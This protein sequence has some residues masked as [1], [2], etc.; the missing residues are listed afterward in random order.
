[1]QSKESVG[2]QQ[3][4][5][6]E[7]GDVFD[8]LTALKNANVSAWNVWRKHHPEIRPNLDGVQLKGLDLSG[9]DFS[10]LSIQNAKINHCNLSSAKLISTRL[11]GSDLSKTD[12]SGARLIA[13]NLDDAN[14]SH[15]RLVHSNLLTAS[16]KGASLKY[17]D[18]RGQDLN[19]LALKNTDL[20]GSNL[21]GQNLSNHDLSGVVLVDVIIEK[22]NLSGAN[23]AYSIISN[24][25]FKNVAF[26]KNSFYKATLEKVNLSSCDLSFAN[27]SQAQ[28]LNC[29]FREASLV[30]ANLQN[31]D[32][33]DSKFWRLNYSDWNIDKIICERAYW[34]RTAKERTSYRRFDF[35]RI[36]ATPI[37][38]NLKYPYRLTAHE[39]VTLPIFI[40]HLQACHW[41]I[42]LRLKSIE[43]EAGGAT[44]TLV[45]DEIAHFI[46]SAL[47]EEIQQEAARIQQAQLMLRN[48]HKTHLELK[49]SVAAI[50]EKF[51][52]R[53]LELAAEHEQERVRNLTIVFM[54]LKGFSRWGD[55][56]RSQKL[57]LFRGLLKPILKKWRGSFPNMEGDSL[58]IT[59]RNASVGLACACMISKVLTAAGFQLRLGVD[60]GEVAIVHNEVTE[61]ADLEGSA[62]ALAAR[63][64]AVAEPG[65]VL[66]TEMVRHYA[67]NKGV[68]DFNRRQVKLAKSI[69]TKNAGDLIECHSV[70]MLKQLPDSF[71]DSD[72]D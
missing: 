49:E 68:F 72:Q 62:V 5:S 44:V 22:A 6:R 55:E 52:P 23:L 46:P 41:G 27:F 3:T 56:E 37:S 35:E 1:M 15:C 57:S 69:G 39:M 24:V 11:T 71:S 14:L 61:Q 13:A 64:E 4:N 42:V 65:E 30:N 31:A 50:K 18:F 43:D 66:A 28:L 48:D 34:D 38:V 45:V 7:T 63:L 2:T 10:K 12:F 8:Y 21:Q 20:T 54:D 70:T 19:G 26:S 60:L 25:H 51:W 47:R 59:F 9:I 16:V 33:T 29:D 17:I 36:Y 32:I 40:E 53:L 67:D 58:R